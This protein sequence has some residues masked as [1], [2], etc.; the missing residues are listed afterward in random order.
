ASFTASPASSDLGTPNSSALG[1]LDTNTK[2]GDTP[3][4][5]G[6]DGNNKYKWIAGD[7][8]NRLWWDVNAYTTR[9]T[10][11]TIEYAQHNINVQKKDLGNGLTQWKITF[12]PGQGIW[13]KGWGAASNYPLQQGQMGFYLTSDYQIIGDVNIHTSIIPGTTY[14]LEGTGG[15]VKVRDSADDLDSG[16]VN[17]KSDIPFKPGDVNQTNGVIS[18]TMNPY[19]HLG[20]YA[21][22]WHMSKDNFDKSVFS[23]WVSDNKDK[24]GNSFARN[25]EFDEATARAGQNSKDMVVNQ[26]PFKENK[27]FNKD[28]IGTALY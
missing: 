22:I 20:R 1:T 13:Y 21:D 2:E 23:D 3:A 12:Y 8:N 17:P 27:S 25:N 15:G 26:A 14:Q 4:Y 24:I 19:Y 10:G 11:Q 28:T 6:Q 5:W 9:D 7:K 18:S 16:N